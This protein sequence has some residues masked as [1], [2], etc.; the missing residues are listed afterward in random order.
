MAISTGR[1]RGWMK[2]LLLAATCALAAPA[3]A[4]TSG[5]VVFRVTTVSYGGKYGD[6]NIG[7]I[8]VED[9]QNRFVKTLAVW[10]SKRIRHLIKWQAASGGNKVDAV[11]SA[12]LRS[13]RSHEV[14]W[15]CTDA[16]GNLVPDGPYQIFVEFTEDNSSKSGHPPGKWTSVS[17]TKGP[18][19]QTVN[20]PDQTYFKSMS[21][22]YT[23]GGAA[24][25]T[26]SIAGTIRDA[27]S[28]N[29][30][31][32]AT[33][34][35]MNGG[36]EVQSVQTGNGG[37]YQFA[38][39]SSGGYT[40][41]ASASGYQSAETSVSLQPGEVLTGVDLSLQPQAQPASLA[42]IVLDAATGQPIAGA[43][44]QLQQNGNVQH[45]TTTA[46]DGKFSLTAIPPGSYTLSAF[47]SGYESHSE[48]LSLADGEQ[49]QNKEIRLAPV[50]NGATLSGVVKDA[51]SGQP[52][53]GARVQLRRAGQV[54]YETTSGSDGRYEFRDVAPGDYALMAQKAGYAEWSRQITL[55]AGQNITGRDI[56]LTADPTVDE[57]PPQAPRNLRA[58]KIGN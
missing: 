32:G 8:W 7:A 46:A 42:G 54:A 53:A 56:L 28:G 44:V 43:T 22:V 14:T 45:E 49:V 3:A 21:L 4:Q 31:A 2:W 48:A 40:V 29:G 37:T 52:V 26:G 27:R 10:G 18:S 30:L 39:V 57:T 17:F 33:V 25:Q 55:S 23:A 58:R 12:T 9:A 47:A 24:P 1:K 16:Q 35:L 50:A 15:D 11:T 5:T 38:D 41:A 6:K 13:H 51:G 34:R 36:Q 19:N 20:P